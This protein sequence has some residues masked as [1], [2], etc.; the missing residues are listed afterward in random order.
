MSLSGGCRCGA[1]RY[2]LALD[3]LP[4][5][6]A[7]HCRDCQTSSG[8]AFSQQAPVDEAALAVSGPLVIYEHKTA[9]RVSSQR[10]CAVCHCRLF[11]TNSA[12]PGLAILRA[13]TLD[14][15]DKLHTVAHIWASRKQAWITIPEGVPQWPEGPP[16]A[17]FFAA[18]TKG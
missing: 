4:N 1:V 15:S 12:R 7:C 2:T 10:F 6:Y 16:V 8:S 13:G 17:E 14:E 11:N 5:T 18:M 3:R 9:D